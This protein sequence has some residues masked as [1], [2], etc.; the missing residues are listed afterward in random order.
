MAAAE[1]QL[2]EEPTL[3][4]FLEMLD[5]I[6]ENEEEFFRQIPE[7][8]ITIQVMK[9]KEARNQTASVTATP[10]IGDEGLRE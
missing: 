10:Y 8:P 7:E 6:S 2:D 1:E 4:V 3:E 9:R 5:Y